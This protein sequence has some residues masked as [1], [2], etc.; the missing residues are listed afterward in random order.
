MFDVERLPM[1]SRENFRGWTFASNF[2]DD[3][4]RKPFAEA[5]I[6]WPLIETPAP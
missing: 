4:S 2:L 3:T 5:S 1:D 6:T